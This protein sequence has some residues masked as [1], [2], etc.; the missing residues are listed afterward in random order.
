M[1]RPRR[2]LVFFYKKKIKEKKHTYSEVRYLVK[3]LWV[4][5]VMVH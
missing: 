3:I 1:T 2:E 4:Y 5:P